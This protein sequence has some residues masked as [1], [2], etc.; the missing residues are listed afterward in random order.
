MARNKNS[1]QY[2]LFKKASAGLKGNTTRKQYRY[3]CKK[4]ASWSKEQGIKQIEKVDEDLIQ[5]YSFH[6][7][8]DPFGYSAGTIHTYLA[9][10]CKARGVSMKDISKPRR[11]ANTITKGRQEEANSHG[12]VQETYPEYQRLITLQKALGIRRSE[13]GQ[14]IRGDLKQG[15]DGYLYVHVRKGKGGKSTYQ[16][17]L[18]K[19]EEVVKKIFFEKS[20]GEKIFNSEEMNN[21][22]N[23]HAIRREH[24]IDVYQFFEE[25]IENEDGFEKVLKD[26]LIKAFIDGNKD[27]YDTNRSKYDSKLSRFINDVRD[28]L[29]ILRGENKQRAIQN[30]RPVVYN[31]LA[32]MAT[33]VFAL[34]HWRLDVTIVNY[35]V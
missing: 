34:S 15:K 8:E 2:E 5:E 3:A 17:I 26:R 28:D 33:S 14:L 19:D 9:P 32:L 13:L 35:I 10:I 1:L 21:K 22:I 6:L 29:Y 11:K 25:R 27:L 4:F 20:M 7:Q 31:R 30:G 12:K 23:L 24:A 18:P 16:L